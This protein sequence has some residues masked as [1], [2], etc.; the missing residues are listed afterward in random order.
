MHSIKSITKIL[1][2]ITS[3]CLSINT[4]NAYECN[5]DYCEENEVT[6][7][8]ICLYDEWDDELKTYT[9]DLCEE[10]NVDYSIVLAIIWN[11]S[12]FQS[13][14]TNINSNGTKDYGLMQL[15][16][17]TFEFL[18]EN[19]EIENMEELYDPKTNILAGIT[20]LSYHKEYTEDD[21]LALLRYQVGAGNYQ[22]IM[23]YGYTPSDTYY[24]VLEK[25]E[26]YGYIL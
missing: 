6:D 20:L 2:I 26:E 4:I 3:L 25:S 7:C 9:K 8:Y 15:N 16:D 12:R 14:A 23:E 18:K 21:E 22:D 24:N 19:I 11:E 5:S 10:N 13:D 17:S 1:T